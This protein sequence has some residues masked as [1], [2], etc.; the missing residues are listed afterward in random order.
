MEEK[1][2]GK[3]L[4]VFVVILIL[5]ILGLVGYILYDKGIILS[6]KEEPKVEKEEVKKEE[7]EE[8]DI[9]SRLVQYLYNMV[10]EDSNEGCIAGWEF[11]P[12]IESETNKDGDEVAVEKN[13]IFSNE[14]YNLIDTNLLGRNLNSN[15]KYRID[16]KDVPK[17][18]GRYNY[19]I[20][21]YFTEKDINYI[22]TYYYTKRYVETVYKQVF[23]KQAKLDTSKSIQIAPSL[24]RAK[25]LEELFYDKK[26]ERYYP[27]YLLHGEIGIST[28]IGSQKNKLTRAVKDKDVI[29]LYQDVSTIT[30]VEPNTQTEEY[31]YIYTFELDDDGMYKFVSR[32]KEE[33]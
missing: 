16:S 19:D 15:E 29:K 11:W 12:A 7:K 28:C 31:K 4:V 9:D 13:Y 6:P 22:S 27:Y 18:D 21:A 26:T 17:I 20:N 1:K 5:I 23:G 24:D 8:L 25:G 3:G 32:E 10:T 30:G 33:D 2:K 14:D